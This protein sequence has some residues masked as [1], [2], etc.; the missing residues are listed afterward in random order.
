[1]S[2]VPSSLL[3]ERLDGGSREVGRRHSLPRRALIHALTLGLAAFALFP[4]IWTVASSLKTPAELVLFPPPLFPYQF[5]W[6]N[7]AEMMSVVPFWRW[8]Y[9]SMF[10]TVLGTLGAILSASVVA[11]SFARFRY[12]GRDLFFIVTLATIMLPVEVTII[13]Q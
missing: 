9:N 3:D 11:Y 2:A 10:V 7:Y 1:M 5:Q 13:P 4:F 6:G 12:P 8:V